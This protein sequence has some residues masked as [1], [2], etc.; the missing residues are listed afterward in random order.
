MYIKSHEN[1]TANTKQNIF[2]VK[3]FET[4]LQP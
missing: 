4:V 1:S 3:Y 2:E